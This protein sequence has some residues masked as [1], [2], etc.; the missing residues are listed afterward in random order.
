MPVYSTS[1]FLCK[2][3]Q[4]SKL[5]SWFAAFVQPCFALLWCSECSNVCKATADAKYEAVCAWV[6]SLLHQQQSYAVS[7]GHQ[8]WKTGCD[9]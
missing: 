8:S 6:L 5:Q 3:N 9:D 4:A 2:V 7:I 1:G